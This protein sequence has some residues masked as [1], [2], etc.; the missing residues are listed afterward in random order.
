MSQFWPEFSE[1]LNF[2]K[3]ELN[4]FSKFK[5]FEIDSRTGLQGKG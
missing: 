4:E 3:T 2:G 5:D 1:K